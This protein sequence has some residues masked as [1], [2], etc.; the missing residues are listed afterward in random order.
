MNGDS[1]AQRPRWTRAFLVIGCLALISMLLAACQRGE[2][3]QDGITTQARV[4]LTNISSAELADAV[5]GYSSRDEHERN[6]AFQRIL[7]GGE[8]SVP[9]IRDYVLNGSVPC[10]GKQG[11]PDL[12]VLLK[13]QAAVAALNEVL[14]SALPEDCREPAARSARQMW[15]ER[16]LTILARLAKD[17]SV[18]DLKYSSMLSERAIRESNPD[19]K[20][21]AVRFEPAMMSGRIGDAVTVN[22]TFFFFSPVKKASLTIRHSDE[23]EPI[24]GQA[25]EDFETPDI[26]ATTRTFTFRLTEE[27]TFKVRSILKS[28]LPGDR[29][30]VAEA[31]MTIEVMP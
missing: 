10:D 27:G 3:G 29:L 14:D 5:A 6:E 19:L 23:G 31:Q 12:L 15:D 8:A 22:V 28:H 30:E 17:K 2:D 18:P 4:A 13:G 25:I 20:S 7:S 1:V 24:A 26:S 21:A 11:Y 16:T 9:L